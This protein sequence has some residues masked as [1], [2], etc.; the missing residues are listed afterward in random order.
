MNLVEGWTL[1]IEYQLRTSDGGVD[2]TGST[3]TVQLYDQQW[4]VS[5]ST[6]SLTVTSSTGGKVRWSP[7]T[8]QDLI[9]VKSPYYVRFK[10][11]DA[12]LKI[13]YFPNEAPERWDV[14]R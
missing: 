1:G 2:L 12:S 11:V 9:Q 7:G 14:G 8:T 5:S 3:V 6:G 4:Q 13:A 10:V